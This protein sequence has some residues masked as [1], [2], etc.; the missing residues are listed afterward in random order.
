MRLESISMINWKCFNKKYLEFDQKTMLN[1]KNGEGKTS[2]IQAIV[3]CL[4]DKRPDNLDY[5]S[6]VD[7]EKPTK[8]SLT[9]SHNGYTY[10]AERE[11]G[12]TTGHKLY[13]NDELIA[14]SKA[15]YK[16]FLS[17]IISESVLTS[18]W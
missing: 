12:K 6:L 14:R 2:L 16:S 17:S 5:A 4:F 11:I 10:I 3:I 7:L 18:L 9:F 13:K 1:W 8:I 15:E